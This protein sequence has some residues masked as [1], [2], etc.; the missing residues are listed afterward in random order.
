MVESVIQFMIGS[1]KPALS[2]DLR[3]AEP[4]L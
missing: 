4:Y 2:R 3:Y 1:V